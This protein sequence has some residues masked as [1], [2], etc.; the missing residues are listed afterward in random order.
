MQIW[1]GLAPA[2]I[3][4]LP[5]APSSGRLRKR[6]QPTRGIPPNATGWAGG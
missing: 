1:L 4:A 3:S 5:S 2:F 6:P